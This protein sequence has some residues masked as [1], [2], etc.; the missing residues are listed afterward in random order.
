[1]PEY[2]A[3]DVF[4]EEVPAPPAPSLE[5]A[6]AFEF[7]ARDD[8]PGWST[9]H[10]RASETTAEPEPG[11]LAAHRPGSSEADIALTRLDGAS[12]AASDT[13]DVFDL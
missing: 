8:A 6:D 1:M 13:F 2:L 9:D 11:G 5:P 3:P 4:V 12:P 10:H 7:L